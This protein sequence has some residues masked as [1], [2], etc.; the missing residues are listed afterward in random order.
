MGPVGVEEATEVHMQAVSEALEF[1]RVLG[2]LV[3]GEKC[4]LLASEPGLRAAFK[5][6]VFPGM[7]KPVKQAL[8]MRDLGSH[9]NLAKK[10][11]GTTLSARLTKAI[12][13]A[14]AVGSLP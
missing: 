8:D 7:T 6:H 5:A 11:V 14:R 2:S 3:S 12:P 10:A 9:L 1:F 13:L 4:C